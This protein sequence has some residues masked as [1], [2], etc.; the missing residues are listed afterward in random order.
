VDVVDVTER[1]MAEF[2]D[3]LG[4]DLISRIV[5][6][7]RRDLANKPEGDLPELVERLAR[8][9]LLAAMQ[10]SPLPGPRPPSPESGPARRRPSS[11]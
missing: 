11:P 7:C 9:R 2:E 5:T 4:L 6:V 10:P 1:L 3:R 8:Q